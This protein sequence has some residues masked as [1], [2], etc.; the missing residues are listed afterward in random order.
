[1]SL[2]GRPAARTCAINCLSF[3]LNSLRVAGVGAGLRRSV[4]NAPWCRFNSSQPSSL[5]V[6]YASATVLKC[7]PRSRP[8]LRTVGKESPGRSSPPTRRV[9]SPST[10]C[11]YAGAPEA[12]SMRRVTFRLICCMYTNKQQTAQAG[13]F[14]RLQ[15]PVFHHA[16]QLLRPSLIHAFRASVCFSRAPGG[17]MNSCL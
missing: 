2:G 15:Y 9:R 17:D 5:N 1:M 13:N 4:T 12:R 11:R 14:P 3:V 8:R 16:G 7:T 10:I 6:R